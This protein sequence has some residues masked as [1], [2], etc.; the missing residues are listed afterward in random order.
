MLIIDDYCRAMWDYMLK[1]KGEAKMVFQRFLAQ[2]ENETD[3]KVKGM[4][5]DRGGECLPKEFSMVCETKGIARY[6]TA[7]Y[8]PQQNGVVERRNRTVM[9]MARSLLKSKFLPG[10]FRGE[11]VRHVVYILNHAATRVLNGVMP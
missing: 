10:R 4:R 8:S 1:G 3:H 5:S 7:L 2:A 11:A 6:F 9:A